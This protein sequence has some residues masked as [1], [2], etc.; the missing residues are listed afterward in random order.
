VLNEGLRTTG[1]G[2]STG[3]HH[4]SFTPSH[5]SGASMFRM[6]CGTPGSFLAT[7]LS[8]D[9]NDSVFVRRVVGA[10]QAGLSSSQSPKTQIHYAIVPWYPGSS[11]VICGMVCCY[12]YLGFVVRADISSATH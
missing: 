9:N 4:Q 2:E 11:G 8:K 5:R 10:V 6:P 3:S 12:M 7:W 1:C